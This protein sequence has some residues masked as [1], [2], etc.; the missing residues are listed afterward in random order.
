VP[1]SASAPGSDRASASPRLRVLLCGLAAVRRGCR[2][3]HPSSKKTEDVR[4]TAAGSGGAGSAPLQSAGD[5]VVVVQ[6]RPLPPRGLKAAGGASV[7]AGAR[8]S[9]APIAHN[10]R[11]L[12]AASI[13]PAA[14]KLASTRWQKAASQNTAARSAEA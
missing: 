11:R 4:C 2:A 1:S 8:R 7:G 13:L 6:S 14:S 5:S 12:H 3:Q 9:M 10:V